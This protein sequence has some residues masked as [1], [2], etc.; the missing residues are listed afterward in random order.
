MTE[1]DI[2][3]IG[4]GIGALSVAGELC[5]NG[6]KVLVITKGLKKSCNSSLAQGGISVALSDKDNYEWHY[7]D[8]MAAGCNLNDSD[9]VMKLVSTAP[10]VIRELIDTGMEFDRDSQG[11]LMFGR[12]AA[13]RLNRVIHAGGDRTGLRVVEQLIRNLTTD[14]TVIQ[15]QWHLI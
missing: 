10:N 15:N 9:A 13:H 4:S 7:E 8:T 3:I 6:R 5:K 12:E 11:N 1:A 2:I 14:V